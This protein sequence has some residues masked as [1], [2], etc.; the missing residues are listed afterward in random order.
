[1]KKYAVIVAGGN[2][3]RM[4]A[5]KPKQFLEINGK[6]ILKITVEKFITAFDDFE[7]IVVLPE[8][9][10]KIGEQ[11]LS[12][13]IE[14]NHVITT[15]GGETRFDSVKKGLALVPEN[16][17]VFVHDAVRCLVSD[18]LIKRCYQG[19]LENGNAI[20]A[21]EVKDSIRVETENGFEVVDRSRLRIVQTP[22]TFFSNSIKKAFEQNYD[23]S[24]TDE[25]TVAEAYGIKIHLVLGEETNMKITTRSDLQVASSLLRG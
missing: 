19:A 16:A 12:S 15:T 20:P 8:Q 9:H 13:D 6:P 23:P 11:I 1:M 22:Q 5:D 21:I 14:L 2:G 4:G 10:Q 18:E 24:F 7:I 3:S 25:A 17:I